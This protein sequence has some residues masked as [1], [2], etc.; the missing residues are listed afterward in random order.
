M[1]IMGTS[2]E[3]FGGAKT[4]WRISAGTSLIQ[5]NSVP[6]GAAHDG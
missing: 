5:S 2:G 6:V 3:G 4:S 1:R